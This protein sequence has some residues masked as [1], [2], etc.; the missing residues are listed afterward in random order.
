MSKPSDRVFHLTIA[1]FA[2][3]LTV[4][5]GLTVVYQ[6]DPQ[7]IRSW[8]FG[9]QGKT[10]ANV[11]VQPAKSKSAPFGSTPLKP[12]L[13]TRPAPASATDTSGTP[14]VVNASVYVKGYGN[15]VPP[16]TV[17]NVQQL[18][19]QYHIVQTV[20]NSLQ[21]K[22]THPV[23]IYLAQTTADYKNELASLGLSIQDA[24]RLSSDT[25]GF[26]QGTTIIIPL[27]QNTSQADLAN[28]LGHEL[29]HAIVNQHLTDLP[30]WVNEG[31]AVSNGTYIQKKVEGSVAFSGYV[32]RMAENVLGAVQKRELIPLT[33][34]ESQILQGSQPYDLELQDWLAVSRLM[35]LYGSS[36]FSAYFKALQAGVSP[37]AAFQKAFGQS[38]NSFNGTFTQWLQT[39]AGS[40]DGGVTITFVVPQGYSG[41]IR[42]LQHGSSVWQG[43]SVTP[44]TFVLSLT[45]KGTLTGFHG[46]VQ[47]TTDGSS[48]DNSTTYVNLDPARPLYYKGQKVLNA[49]FAIDYHDG[50]YGFINNWITTQNGKTTYS[51]VPDLFGVQIAKVAETTVTNPAL[52]LLNH[53]QS[54]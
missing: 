18:L 30:S 14:A 37:N 26:T 53:P 46:P 50:M 10:P 7:T 43:V 52:A 15:D 12:G 22:I 4:L 16:A 1:A 40:A 35:Q 42:M 48:P 39:A 47:T 36:A 24:Q 33:A 34:S 29:T 44:G 20:S 49:G 38:E 11:P 19:S 23:Y 3:T 41:Y 28:S 21:M 31:T 27:Y 6:R 5:S 8:L 2:L 51:R 13:S 45:P 25:G 32:R 17:S 9:Q 54:P